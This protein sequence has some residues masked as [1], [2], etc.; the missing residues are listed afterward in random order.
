VGHSGTQAP[1][2]MQSSLI[3]MDMGYYSFVKYIS[4]F[5]KNNPCREVRQMTNVQCFD[6]FCHGSSL[7]EV[8]V[9]KMPLRITPLSQILSLG[10]KIPSR[11]NACTCGNH[12]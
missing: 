5:L 3:V 6:K 1:Q 4:S 7:Q 12:L 11:K 10:Q 9:I 2:A 8:I